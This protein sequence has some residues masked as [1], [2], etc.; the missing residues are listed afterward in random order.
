[1]QRLPHELR[2]LRVLRPRAHA[3]V[4]RVPHVSLASA[5]VAAALAAAHAAACAAAT[6]ATAAA[7]GAAAAAFGAV[8][9]IRPSAST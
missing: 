1:M 5:L 6:H 3:Q 2:G 8:A 9:A 4:V 7:L